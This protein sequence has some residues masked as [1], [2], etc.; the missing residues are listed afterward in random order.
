MDT[1]L[2]TGNPTPPPISDSSGPDDERIWRE[3]H[4]PALMAIA[5]TPLTPEQEVDILAFE[6][7]HAVEVAKMMAII[8]TI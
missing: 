7:A 8:F 3:Q 1:M 4:I 2:E 5:N 6:R